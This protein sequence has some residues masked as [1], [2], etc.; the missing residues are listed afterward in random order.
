M[1]DVR[2]IAK[3]VEALPPDDLAK[4]RRWFAAYDAAAWDKQ[5][6]ADVARGRLDSLE[7]EALEDFRSGSKR[8]P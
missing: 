4:F 7:A 8:E 2:A 5:I 3:A 1:G 6:E